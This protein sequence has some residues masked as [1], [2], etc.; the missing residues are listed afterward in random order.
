MMMSH[1][2]LG[3]LGLL[4]AG[5]GDVR[6][7]AV[8]LRE[9]KHCAMSSWRERLMSMATETDDGDVDGDLRRRQS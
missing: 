5:A 3:I 4:G 7:L 6:P 8:L 2:P 9:K 1:V